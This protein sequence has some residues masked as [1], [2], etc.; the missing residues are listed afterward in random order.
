LDGIEL[1]MAHGY[2]L[3]QFLSPLANRRNDQYGGSLENRMRLPLEVFRRR[4]RSLPE[5]ASR[6][7]AHLRIRLGRAADGTSNNPSSLPGNLE[8]AGCATPFTSRRAAYHRTNRLPLD[9]ATRSALH[10][11]SR[12]AV[13]MPVIAVGLITEPEQA[14]D[15]LAEGDADAV[16]LA[17]AM[18][19]NPRWPW[20]AAASLGAQV[21]APPQYWRSPPHGV[22]NLFKDAAFGQR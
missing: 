9:Q 19:Y 20:H 21:A 7:G 12:S 2:L 22:R 1:H 10:V 5:R 11:R 17:R 8:A 14:E 13:S 18:L 4:A 3:H 6:L 15:V 16:A